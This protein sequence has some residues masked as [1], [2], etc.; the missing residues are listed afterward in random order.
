MWIFLFIWAGGVQINQIIVR[1]ERNQEE[2]SFINKLI[3]WLL[4][5]AVK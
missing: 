3:A 4:S 5:I 2:E 1:V